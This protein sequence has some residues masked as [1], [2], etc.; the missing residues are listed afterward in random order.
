MVTAGA[1][2]PW[3]REWGT[4]KAHGHTGDNLV[5][6]LIHPATALFLSLGILFPSPGHALDPAASGPVVP[7]A[8]LS[9]VIPAEIR[10]DATLSLAPLSL[11]N[12]LVAA[13]LSV[14]LPDRPRAPD[15][16][17]SRAATSAAPR[18][19]QFDRNLT[20]RRGDTLMPLLVKAGADRGDA[21]DAIRA[22]AT[23]YDPRRLKPGQELVVSFRSPIETPSEIALIGV[24]LDVD[25]A[26]RVLVSRDKTGLF[27][28]RELEKALTRA[29]VAAA[30]I[31][32]SS[33]FEATA[34]ADVP[35]PIITE[36][37]RLFS[38]DVDFQR[39]IQPGDAF[40]VLYE[41]LEDDNGV[42]VYHG[43]ILHASLTLSGKT[44]A[45]YRHALADGDE[46]Y[47]D[48]KGKGAKK[49]LM[50]TP[51]DG[52]R[53]SSRYGKRRHPVLRFTRMH[54]GIDFAAPR[55]TPIYAAGDGR[56]V[57]AGRNGGYGRYVRIR[58]NGSFD[59][60]YGHLKGYG[61]GVR[62][63]ARVKQGQI[64]GYVGTS[65]LSTGPHLHYEIL[66]DNRQVNPLTVK[67][68][69][70]RAL[71]GKELAR[72]QEARGGIDR[73]WTALVSV[74]AVAA[75]EQ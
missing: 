7:V 43:R 61:R 5:S 10:D 39:D 20:V 12:P 42:A 13:T 74:P 22:L 64:I 36:L 31:I 46:D 8:P 50:R 29:P 73:Q 33:L 2:T 51:I 48:E 40:K 69:S 58:H 30:G 37:I 18:A 62:R 70:G 11:G 32:R 35:V 41:N 53:L 14:R 17:P 24:S 28:A 3:G 57:A 38:W 45:I 26:R 59:T 49:A 44:T 67:M 65:G 27:D 16:D 23:T 21:H 54:R 19:I 75:R 25:H 9:A 47:F 60:A 1:R 15:E 66:R 71:K 4:H 56:V 63:G 6:V 52:A 68:P 34:K 55:G 72:F